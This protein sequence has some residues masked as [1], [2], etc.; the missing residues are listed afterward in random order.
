MA[1][2]LWTLAGLSMAIGLYFTFTHPEPEFVSPSWLMPSAVGVAVAGIL[3][4]WVTYQRRAIDP[5][6]FTTAFAPIYKAALA[7]FWIDDLFE[8]VVAAS[9]LAFSRAVGWVDRYLVDK[10][11][12]RYA[13]LNEAIGALE[14]AKLELY[15]RLA[16][17]YEDEKIRESGDVYGA[18][19]RTP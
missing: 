15:R 1:L 9:V 11:G 6:G 3:L 5:A 16:A 18:G 10:G 14:S 19:E 4:A 17:P 8:K 13:H 2:P 12:I 7:K